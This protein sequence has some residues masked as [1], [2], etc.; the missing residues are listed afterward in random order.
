MAFESVQ[1]CTAAHEPFP[2]DL[3][4]VVGGTNAN[5]DMKRLSSR[6][7]DILV[8]TPGRMIDLLQNSGLKRQLE[9]LRT[10]IFDEADR[11]LDM[12]F[13]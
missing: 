8:G 9:G 2:A 1:R 3:Q 13:K 10:L 11:L 4:S 5:A 12:G 7:P 6:V